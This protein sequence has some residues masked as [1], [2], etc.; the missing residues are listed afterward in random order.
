MEA[1]D[2]ANRRDLVV[3][4]FTFGDKRFTMFHKVLRS[5]RWH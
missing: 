3:S 5:Q 4:V 1:M 2:D